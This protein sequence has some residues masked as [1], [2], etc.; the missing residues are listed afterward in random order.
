MSYAKEGVEV[1]ALERSRPEKFDHTSNQKKLLKRF[2]YID[3]ATRALILNIIEANARHWY[4][5]AGGSRANFERLFNNEL[6]AEQ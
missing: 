4:C 3:P 1:N 5:E 6:H 2:G